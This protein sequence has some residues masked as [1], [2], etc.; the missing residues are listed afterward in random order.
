MVG[1]AGGK[2]FRNRASP[3][4]SP[5]GR[6]RSSVPGPDLPETR[7]RLHPESAAVQTRPIL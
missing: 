6:S 5:A 1:R 4:T 2:A 3:K 7:A